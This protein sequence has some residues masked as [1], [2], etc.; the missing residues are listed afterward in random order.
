MYK[1]AYLSSTLALSAIC[2]LDTLVPCV[3]C[4]LHTLVLSVF[5][6]LVFPL[7]VFRKLIS[8]FFFFFF[9]RFFLFVHVYYLIINILI[10]YIYSI[11]LLMTFFFFF[12][13]LFLI[14][15]YPFIYLINLLKITP[16]IMC[17]LFYILLVKFNKFYKP[18]KGSSNFLV[19]IAE[20]HLSYFDKKIPNPPFL[21]KNWWCI[22]KQQIL[23]YIFMCFF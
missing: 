20:H 12:F 17:N 14:F 3:P 4:A 5:L 1:F 23:S 9:G 7:C 10:T 11:I 19:K 16:L 22:Q 13:F 15:S 6:W 18:L 21:G 2:A 8:C